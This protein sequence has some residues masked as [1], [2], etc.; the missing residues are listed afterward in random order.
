MINEKDTVKHIAQGLRIIGVAQF[1]H[2]GG[3][4]MSKGSFSNL[5][6][7]DIATIVVSGCIFVG[8]EALGSVMIE[9]IGRKRRRL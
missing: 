9:N 4:V 8:L 6:F 2:F 3:E 5:P 1:A 7:E